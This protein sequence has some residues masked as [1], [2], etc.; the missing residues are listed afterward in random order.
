[1]VLRYGILCIIIPGAKAIRAVARFW[2]YLSFPIAFVVT[3]RGDFIFAHKTIR[4]RN[5]AGAILFIAFF[6]N[7]RVTGVS[8]SK[9]WRTDLDVNFLENVAIPPVDCKVFY[10]YD[11]GNKKILADSY[12]VTAYEIANHFGIKTVNEYSGGKPRGWRLW[13]VKNKAYAANVYS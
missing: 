1:M 12:Q 2:F 7:M 3:A 6:S 8:F 13:D 9:M 11:S 4:F 10:I 5:I